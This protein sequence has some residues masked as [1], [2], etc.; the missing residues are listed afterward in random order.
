MAKKPA[1]T[2]SAG[3]T[4][5]ISKLVPSRDI[6]RDRTFQDALAAGALGAPAAL[7]ANVDLRKH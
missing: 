1:L 4:D 7:P 2:A 3:F 5:R 6:G